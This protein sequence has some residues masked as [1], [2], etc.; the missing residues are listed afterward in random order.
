MK[1]TVS[2]KRG[3]E[4]ATPLG[5]IEIQAVRKNKKS[6]KWEVIANTLSAFD[7]FYSMPSVPTGNVTLRV[8]PDQIAR[9][10]I[11]KFKSISLFFKEG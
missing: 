1:G 6:G 3:D 11:V 9:L 7:G 4:E 10:A 8:N 2:I 5:N